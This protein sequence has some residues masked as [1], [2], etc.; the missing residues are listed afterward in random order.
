MTPGAIGPCRESRCLEMKG[1]PEDTV[2][3][4]RGVLTSAQEAQE[5]VSGPGEERVSEE[6]TELEER[7]RQG[8]WSCTLWPGRLPRAECSPGILGNGPSRCRWGA[9]AEGPRESRWE[10]VVGWFTLRLEA[11]CGVASHKAQAELARS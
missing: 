1:A 8:D 6:A 3:S 7:G 11:G 4:G 2:K 9:L 5:P 10:S